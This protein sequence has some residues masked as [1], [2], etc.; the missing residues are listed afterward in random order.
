MRAAIYTIDPEGGVVYSSNKNKPIGSTDGRYLSMKISGKKVY[1]H[2]II[3]EHVNGKIPDGM[4][5]DHIDG[6]KLNNKISNLRIGTQSD[7]LQNK[8]VGKCFSI[9]KRGRKKKYIV[10]IKVNKKS[11]SKSFYTEKEAVDYYINKKLEHRFFNKER[12]ND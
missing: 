1:I 8:S 2:R 3:W 11:T 12:L 6:N 5:V 9:D 10:Q 7:N 4:V